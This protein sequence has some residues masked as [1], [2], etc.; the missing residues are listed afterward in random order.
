MAEPKKKRVKGTLPSCPVHQQNKVCRVRQNFSPELEE[1]LCEV[2]SSLLQLSYKF[3]ALAEVFDQDSVALFRVS[4]F[5]HEQSKSEEEAAQLLLKHMANRGGFYCSKTIQKP[6]CEYVR[7][8][9]TALNMALDQWKIMQVYFEELYSLSM[10][11]LDPHSASL[12]KKHFLEPTMK[13]VKLTGDVITN[14]HRLNCTP[15]GRGSF[16]EYLIERL[17]EELTK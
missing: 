17:Q 13:K 6:S 9:M 16:G 7:D 11:C 12:I 15:D 14:A 3:Q 1:S 8:L 2:I 10:D 5:F 4:K